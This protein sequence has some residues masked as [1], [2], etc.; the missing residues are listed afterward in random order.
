MIN[1]KPYYNKIARLTI[2]KPSI[3]C[4]ASNTMEM[5]KKSRLISEPNKIMILENITD[6]A[7]SK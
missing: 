5:I 6:N 7:I 2:T 4:E 1:L 3:W